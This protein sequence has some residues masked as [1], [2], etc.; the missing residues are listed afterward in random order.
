[1]SKSD[2]EAAL[3]EARDLIARVREISADGRRMAGELADAV[4]G[5]AAVQCGAIDER[6]AEIERSLDLIK[7]KLDEA[8]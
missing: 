8:A 4:H 5:I 1:M 2:L 6:A 7:R 3:A